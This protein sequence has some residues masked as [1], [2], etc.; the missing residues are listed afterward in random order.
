MFFVKNN[1]HKNNL[2]NHIHV[3]SDD[4]SCK[5]FPN[6][7]ASIQ[8]FSKKGVDIID[9]IEISEKGLHSY[10]EKYQSALLFPF[11]GRVENGKY[12]FND[13]QYS[14]NINETSRFNALH[15]LITDKSFEI[16][17]SILSETNATISLSYTSDGK[18]EGFPFQ[19][20]FQVTYQ[21]TSEGISLRFHIQNLDVVPFPFGCGWH[22]YFK[23]SSL[24]TSELSFASEKQ[25]VYNK[26][27]IPT[28]TRM[29]EKTT[30]FTIKNRS[31]DD[32]FFLLKNNVRFKSTRYHLNITT[33]SEHPDFLQVYTPPER[34]S[35]ALEPISCAP[36]AF[37]NKIGLI[38]LNPDNSFEWNVHLQITTS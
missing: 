16:D 7:G 1:T 9:G 14:L 29:I 4:V 24:H 13:V 35:I 8:Q 5:L 12:I 6:L 33:K 28:D 23:S 17:S 19:F 36:N 18:L 34:N 10:K 30:N 2:L 26:N 3:F 21:L 11:I 32:T 20:K 25:L 38:E 37:N 27:L 31:F 15:G 22:P